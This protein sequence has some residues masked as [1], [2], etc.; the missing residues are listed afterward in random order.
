MDFEKKV[1][2][3]IPENLYYGE[4]HFLD[5]EIEFVY[6]YKQVAIFP[7]FVHMYMM[8]YCCQKFTLA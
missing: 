6:T 8:V 7:L 1:N 4:F 3:R 5:N 2:E